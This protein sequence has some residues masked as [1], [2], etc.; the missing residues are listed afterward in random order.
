MKGNDKANIVNVVCK[1][2][3][4]KR[5]VDL[6]ISSQDVYKNN[7]KFTKMATLTKMLIF[8]VFIIKAN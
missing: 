3:V 8:L 4:E 1:K 6:K 5:T 7:I 2:W